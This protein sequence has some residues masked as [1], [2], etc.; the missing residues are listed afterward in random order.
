MVTK[1]KSII[2]VFKISKAQITLDNRNFTCKEFDKRAETSWNEGKD[3][4][5][6]NLRAPDAALS[7]NSHP[8]TS[9]YELN[10][11]QINCTKLLPW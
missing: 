6:V 11:L 7:E 8:R 5:I 3:I 4:Y 2:Y 10:T 1:A 9:A